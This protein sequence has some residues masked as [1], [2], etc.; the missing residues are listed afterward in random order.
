VG[1]KNSEEIVVFHLLFVDE[2]LI[3]RE[4]NSEQH[5]NLCSL[6]M[7]RNGVGLKINLSKSVIFPVGEVVD[8]ENF[9]KIFRCRVL[10]KYL[11]L[12][13]GASYKSTR[14]WL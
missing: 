2:T 1:L 8:V 10:M 14:C 12:P 11:G 6:F 5:Y 4:A 13:L 3:F 9:A 7:F